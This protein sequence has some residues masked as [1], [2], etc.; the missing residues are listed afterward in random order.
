MDLQRKQLER[1]LKAINRLAAKLDMTPI[2][3]SDFQHN[4]D[5]VLTLVRADSHDRM[6]GQ[7]AE[8]LTDAGA[9]IHMALGTKIAIL[10]NNKLVKYNKSIIKIT[11]TKRE[12]GYGEAAQ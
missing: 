3:W 9:K 12:A 8:L 2:S 5:L 1:N 4:G 6:A 10:P 11:K 7:L